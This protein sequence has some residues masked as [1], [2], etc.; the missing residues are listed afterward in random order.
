MGETTPVAHG[1]DHG[2]RSWFVRVR[3]WRGLRPSVAY[4]QVTVRQLSLVS[5]AKREWGKPRQS[6]MG[7]TPKTAL[8]SQDRAN[9]ANQ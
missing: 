7:G 4:G 6:L 1:G 8:P 2:S 3:L 5:H 9:H